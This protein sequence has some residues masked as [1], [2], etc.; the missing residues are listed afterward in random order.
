ML[1]QMN[2]LIGSNKQFDYFS[3]NAFDII[4]NSS[5]HHN[6]QLMERFRVAINKKKKLAEVTLQHNFLHIYI[7][8]YYNNI[9]KYKRFIKNISICLYE[10]SIYN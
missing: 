5:K 1:K 9:S 10:K 6:T 4:V 8:K 3:K 2:T 7:A